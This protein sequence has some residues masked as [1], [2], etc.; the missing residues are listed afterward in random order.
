MISEDD[1][2]YPRSAQQPWNQLPLLQALWRYLKTWR[3]LRVGQ[4]S[5]IYR[6]RRTTTVSSKRRVRQPQRPTFVQ[7]PQSNLGAANAVEPRGGAAAPEI[8]L[9][10][11]VG[12]GL[13]D[14]LARK[15]VSAGFRVA[16]VSRRTEHLLGLHADLLRQGGPGSVE[17]FAADA[18]DEL[19]VTAVFSSVVRDMGTP[20]LAIYAVQGFSPGRAIEVEVDAFEDCWRQN[21]MGAFIVAREAARA[22]QPE[23]RGSILLIG[24][25]SGMVGRANYL[26]LAVGKFGLRAISQ[27]MARELWRD[28]IHVAHLVIDADIEEDVDPAS[29]Q[30]NP[31]DI[32]DLII[33]LH[34][35]PKSTWSSEMDVRPFN[36]TFWEHC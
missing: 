19:S 35:Q 16:L 23:G 26:N 28:G 15:M 33:S 8:V 14:A 12:L 9:L 24:C 21:C 36:E 5:L 22:M 11:G 34:R 2:D 18:T 6:F 32:A 27:V 30:T 17:L 31:A 20:T 10:F 25:T 13:G 4:V 29:P 1:R 7:D 3:T